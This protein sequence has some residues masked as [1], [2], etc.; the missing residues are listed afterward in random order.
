MSDL[1]AP[2]LSSLVDHLLREDSRSLDRLYAD[3]QAV[4]VLD[5]TAIVR[6]AP[7]GSTDR[8]PFLAR[9]SLL[10][11]AIPGVGAALEACSSAGEAHNAAVGRESAITP[12]A[13]PD[14]ANRRTTSTIFQQRQR[15]CSSA[16]GNA[17]AGTHH[18]MFSRAVT[19]PLPLAADNHHACPCHTGD[20]PVR[21]APGKIV[22]AWTF[23]RD[24]PKPFVHCRVG[25]P[26]DGT[27]TDHVDTLHPMD[28]HA[29]QIEPTH[30]IRSVAKEQL[31]QCFVSPISVRPCMYHCG[32]APATIHVGADLHGAIVNALFKP[33][34]PTKEFVIVQ[35][36]LYLAQAMNGVQAF[37]HAK[38]TDV[39]PDFVFYRRCP[40][41]Y[42]NAP[43]RVKVGDRVRFWLASADPA[44]P[45]H[46][47]VV[48]ESF[49]TVHP[50]A[51][52]NTPLRGVQTFLMP[53]G[54][55]TMFE[56]VCDVAGAFPFVN[57]GF[58]HEQKGAIGLLV[59]EP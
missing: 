53:A 29:A 15:W 6:P 58:G 2:R 47:H 3:D 27:L 50:G 36:A 52:P 24:I 54:G 28:V 11:R 33:L 42:I 31:T 38:M 8:R 32:T 51:P 43:I 22:E 44:L 4:L 23:K 59:V 48:G 46:F 12:D 57:H 45:S 56:L 40:H 14:H 55:S 34:P 10:S 21:I 5:S 26:A 1:I 9:A 49:D 18:T 19:S 25:E 37:D 35:S 16:T 13:P 30:A 20:K 17:K 7:V 41:R 39:L